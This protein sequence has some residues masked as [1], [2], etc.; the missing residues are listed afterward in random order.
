MQNII[1]RFAFI[2]SFLSSYS[3]NTTIEPLIVEDENGKIITNNEEKRIFFTKLHLKKEYENQQLS[4]ARANLTAV[5]MC[6]NGGFEQHENISGSQ[7]LKNFLYTIGDPPG[8]TQCQSI[9]NT[10]NSYIDIYDPSN[11]SVMATTVP[12]NLIDYYIGNINAFDQYALKINHESSSTYGSI[13]QG[14][15]FKTNNENYL[16]YNFKAVLMTVYDTGHADNQPFIKARIINSSG[17]V[18]DEFCLIGDESNC[19]FTKI[20]GSGAAILYTANWQSGLLDI[21]SIPNNEEFTVEFMASRCGF[22]AHFGYMYVDDV[23]LLHSTENLQGS[24]E[25]APL[26]KVCSTLPINVCGSYTVPNS[27]GITAT[28]GTITLNLYNSSGTSVYSTTT[29]T[30]LDTTNKQFCFTLNPANFPDILNANYN[31]G[32]TATYNISGSSSC[33]GT[34]FEPAIDPDA[35]SGWDISF[36]NCSSTCSFDVSTTKLSLCDSNHD[37]TENFNLTNANASMVS[38]TTGFT[39]SYF[40]TFADATANTNAITNTTSYNSASKTIYVRVSQNATCFKVIAIQLEVK[41][42]NVNIS[43]ILNVC[44]GSTVLTATPGATYLWNNGSATQSITVTSIGT[45]SVT[46]TDSNGCA[47]TASVTIEPSQTATVPNVII[48]QPSC[49]VTTGS[50]QIT[51]TASQ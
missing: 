6:T 42:P 44:S 36:Q 15:R 29:T 7:K 35:N 9:T 43:G 2:L 26:N 50:I 4:V 41:N 16:K 49:F 33:P 3:Q 31:V 30:S 40:S 45:Y 14:K 28:L 8:P 22:G 10:A 38:S 21:S 11:T 48:T 39:F 51:S 12:A 23:C 19:I 46:V 1:L 34:I 17:I 32:V 25:L 47:N 13:V 20:P 24:I 27:G 37:G 5:E 18:V